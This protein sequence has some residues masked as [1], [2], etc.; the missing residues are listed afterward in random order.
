[1]L[2]SGE[3]FDLLLSNLMMPEMGGM[4][5]QRRS[6]RNWRRVNKKGHPEV[7]NPSEKIRPS[8]FTTLIS[9]LTEEERKSVKE[10]LGRLP[11]IFRQCECYLRDYEAGEQNVIKLLNVMGD[12]REMIAEARD[13]LIGRHRIPDFPMR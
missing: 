11:M 8:S 6:L 12:T 10:L 3:E 13:G 2:D 7:K 5:L 9:E 1:M 4:E